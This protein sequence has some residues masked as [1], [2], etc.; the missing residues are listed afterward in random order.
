MSLLI[1]IQWLGIYYPAGILVPVTT[2]T[3]ANQ[4]TD[5]ISQDTLGGWKFQLTVGNLIRDTQHLTT[6]SGGAAHCLCGQLTTQKIGEQRKFS[7]DTPELT[8]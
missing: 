3:G 4:I 6:F 2:V 8:S 7:Y 1:W 5:K